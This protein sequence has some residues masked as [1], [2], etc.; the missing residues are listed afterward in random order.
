MQRDVKICRD[1]QMGCGESLREDGFY[2]LGDNKKPS[3]DIF[4]SK[5]F[6]EEPGALQLH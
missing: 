2:L 6:S 1:K 5:S 3:I 4:I